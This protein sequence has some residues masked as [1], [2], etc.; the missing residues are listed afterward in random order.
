MRNALERGQEYFGYAARCEFT[1]STRKQ[2]S[3]R[4]YFGLPAAVR[5]HTHSGKAGR[6]VGKSILAANRWVASKVALFI[7]ASQ[8]SAARIIEI[9]VKP[10][11]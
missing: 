8:D 2:A 9:H 1:P 10:E 11:L 6:P 4:K 5:W 7:W 3:G